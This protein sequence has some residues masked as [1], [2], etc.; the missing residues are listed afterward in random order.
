MD[1]ECSGTL[2]SQ[3][4]NQIAGLET[5]RCS[6]DQGDRSGA[7]GRRLHQISVRKRANYAKRELTKRNR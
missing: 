1:V 6:A 4:T 3:E 7:A 2:V 5:A